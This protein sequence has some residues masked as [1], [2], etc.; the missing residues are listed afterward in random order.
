MM[1]MDFRSRNSGVE[2]V[3]PNYATPTHQIIKG[4]GYWHGPTSGFAGWASGTKKVRKDQTAWT[5]EEGAELIVRPSDGAILTPLKANDAVIP[6][7]FTDNL[8]KWGAI[9]PDSFAVNP[10]MG[11]WGDTTGGSNS[12]DV[13]SNNTANQNIDMHFDSL[14]RVD[15]NVDADVADRLEDLVKGL[16]KNKEFQQNVINFVTKDFVRESRKQGFR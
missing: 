9:N 12:N 8:F 2:D 1:Y 10:F 3:S 14:I 13:L 11:K 15:G 5:Q 16:T 4:S 6:A 7:N